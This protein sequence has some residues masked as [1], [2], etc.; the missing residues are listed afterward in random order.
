M[1]KKN[2]YSKGDYADTNSNG[3]M[4]S[5]SLEKGVKIF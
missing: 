5:K 1:N 2:Q 4:G 3:V